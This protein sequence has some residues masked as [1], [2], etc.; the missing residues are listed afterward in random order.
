VTSLAATALERRT[1]RRVGAAS[2][3]QYD[4]AIDDRLWPRGSSPVG[5]AEPQMIGPGG[6][7]GPAAR[8]RGVVHGV[9]GA[10]TRHRPLPRTRWCTVRSWRETDGCPSRPRRDSVHRDRPLPQPA[11]HQQP[12]G[13]WPEPSASSRAS[14]V[15]VGCRPR[16][17]AREPAAHVSA[18]PI[19]P[20]RPL[21]VDVICDRRTCPRPEMSAIR[22]NA[23]DASSTADSSAVTA[24]TASSRESSSA[25]SRDPA[26]RLRRRPAHPAE[27]PPTPAWVATHRHLGSAPRGSSTPH[28][29][30]P[31]YRRPAPGPLTVR[32]DPSS[33]H[34]R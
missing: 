20:G 18:V 13:P 3:K 14:D 21:P 28:S 34:E 25:A 11:Q 27:K 16:P 30:A 1:G 6:P 29:G 19:P 9:G 10:L 17:G 23:A 7:L 31:A 32:A 26:Q 4:P 15:T 2:A 8:R 22:K 5:D 12:A 24:P 33:G